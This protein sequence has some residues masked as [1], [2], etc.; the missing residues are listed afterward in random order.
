M[1]DK[2]TG[3][4]TGM[5]SAKKAPKRRRKAGVLLG[6]LAA[7]IV[8]AGAGFFVWHEQPSFCSAIC[9]TPM[10][11]YLPTYEAEP[12]KASVDKWGNEVEDASSMMAALHRTNASEATCLD[13]H[14]PTLSQQIGEGVAWASGSYEVVEND[15]FGLV[16]EERSVA[17]LAEATGKTEEQFCLRGGCH[18]YDEKSLAETT[19]DMTFNPHNDIH[20]STDC[21]DCHK[22][23]RT[24]VMACTECHNQAE[25][26]EGWLTAAEASRITT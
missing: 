2:G 18:Q 16:I 1:S 4:V 21:G 17:Q 8:I 3:Q 10:D 13:C 7:I 19:K 15:V 25:V 26:P 9:H 24:S 20:N 14:E 23:H 5:E 22:A 6:T 11:P 12:G